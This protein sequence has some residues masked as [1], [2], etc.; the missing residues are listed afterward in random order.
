MDPACIYTR[1]LNLIPMSPALMEALLAADPASAACMAGHAIPP[2]AE[3]P[4]ETLPV[5]LKQLRQDP[6]L[7]PW[8]IQCFYHKSS[9]RIC[10]NR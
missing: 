5:R 7:V 8:L 1:R 3:V 4:P 6:R 9:P 2:E 10:Y